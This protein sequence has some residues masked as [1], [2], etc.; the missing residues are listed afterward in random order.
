MRSV[1]YVRSSSYPSS[2]PALQTSCHKTKQNKQSRGDSG[3]SVTSH[4]PLSKQVTLHESI[5]DGQ[6]PR[7]QS[8][9]TGFP[10][11]MFGEWPPLLIAWQRVPCL[12]R[13]GQQCDSQILYRSHCVRGAFEQARDD[14]HLSVLW[15]EIQWCQKSEHQRSSSQL[16][17]RRGDNTENPPKKSGWNQLLQI[18]E[19]WCDVTVTSWPCTSCGGGPQRAAALTP[20]THPSF[21]YLVI[22]LCAKRKQ[23]TATTMARADA[24]WSISRQADRLFPVC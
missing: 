12:H 8:L 10:A 2:I 6:S 7:L 4:H 21:S 16:V 19:R 3:P 11:D 24:R 22:S 1:M 13:N 15:K 5:F 20:R 14:C 17:E 23:S 9:C 18:P